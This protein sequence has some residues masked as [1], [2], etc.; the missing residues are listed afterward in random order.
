MVMFK[1]S[2][3]LSFIYFD[4]FI[5]ISNVYSLCPPQISLPFS[6][7]SPCY[8]PPLLFMSTPHIHCNLWS[9]VSTVW[10]NAD[11]LCWLD[12]VQV[13]VG[14]HSCSDLMC[15]MAV[16]CQK[17]TL[18]STLPHASILFTPSEMVPEPWVGCWYSCPI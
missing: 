3:F 10:W 9:P 8:L 2:F 18:H 12:L 1:L 5:H 14:L 17:T 15:A 6:S 7:G 16:S 11:W 4:N 13:S